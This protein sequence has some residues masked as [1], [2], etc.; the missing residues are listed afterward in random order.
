MSYERFFRREETPTIPTMPIISAEEQVRGE[1]E[2]Q[3]KWRRLMESPFFQGISEVLECYER[4][5][6][7]RQNPKFRQTGPTHDGKSNEGD[8]GFIVPTDE[9]HHDVRVNLVCAETQTDLKPK[10][11]IMGSSQASGDYEDGGF[12]EYYWTTPNLS[13]EPLSGSMRRSHAI[14]LRTLSLE[15]LAKELARFELR[16][17]RERYHSD[18]SDPP[19]PPQTP[20]DKRAWKKIFKDRDKDR[21]R[22]DDAHYD[23]G[24]MGAG[25]G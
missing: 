17:R 23:G 5:R 20:A 12:G 22:S 10:Y 1:Q 15:D 4:I 24:D 13:D 8:I 9:E 21:K 16:D 14:R 11:F 3:E 6:F 2:Y 19:W 25:I 7:N 18:P